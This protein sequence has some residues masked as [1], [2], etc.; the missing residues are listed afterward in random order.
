MKSCGATNTF[1][2][3]MIS[4]G[5]TDGGGSTTLDTDKD[6]LNALILSQWKTAGF[7]GVLPFGEDARI[8]ADGVNTG[9]C[10][11]SDH[12]HLV[13]SCQNFL[14]A[15]ASN[16]YNYVFGS[17]VANP[18]I[19][20]TLPYTQVATDGAISLAGVTSAGNITATDC[21][22]PIGVSF[23]INNPQSTFAVT[24]TP[25]SG[26]PA[27]GITSA[28]TIPA[29]SSMTFRSVANAPSVFGCPWEF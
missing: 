5:G 1:V 23:V 13:Q 18:H 9:T 15:W 4:R 14:F 12:I 22:S 29:N 3:T 21:I 26:E 20:T 7:S 24:W 19:V 6:A 28:I 10:F 2:G 8:G 25:L 27:N 16:A 11:Q 17:T